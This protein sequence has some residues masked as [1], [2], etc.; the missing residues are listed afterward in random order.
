MMMMITFIRTV[1]M[2]PSF[3]HNHC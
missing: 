1:F 3:W 2:K